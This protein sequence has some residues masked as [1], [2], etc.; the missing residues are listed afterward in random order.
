[1]NSWDSE[2]VIITVAP[3]GAEVTRSNH[4]DVPFTPSEIAFASLE[5]VAQGASVVHLHAREPDGTP[6]GDPDLFSEAIRL[7]RDKAA[8]IIMASTGGAV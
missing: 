4:P 7:I 1:M 6:S 8:P 3:V 5:A 2:P